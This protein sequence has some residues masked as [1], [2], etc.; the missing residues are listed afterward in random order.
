MC[1]I[2][3]AGENRFL[4]VPRP[5]GSLRHAQAAYTSIYGKVESRWEK[6]ETGITFTITVPANCEA[7]VHLPD[8]REFT[9]TAGTVTYTT[10][11]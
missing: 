9:Q 2:R 10:E 7:L 6:T 8:G 4:I 3:I 11:G 5:G 1:G